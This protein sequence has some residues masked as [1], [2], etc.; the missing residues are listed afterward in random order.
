MMDKVSKIR[1]DWNYEISA[2]RKRMMS[3]SH[4]LSRYFAKR[5]APEIPKRISNALTAQFYS[6]MGILVSLMKEKLA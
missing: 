1:T 6:E 2:F 5:F 3:H 4:F